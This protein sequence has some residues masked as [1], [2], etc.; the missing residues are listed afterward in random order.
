MTAALAALGG[1]P[2]LCHEELG[3]KG[4][5]K[6]YPKRQQSIQAAH[7]NLLSAPKLIHNSPELAMCVSDATATGLPASMFAESRKILGP[8]PMCGGWRAAVGSLATQGWFASP[9]LRRVRRIM[10]K[11]ALVALEGLKGKTPNAMGTLETSLKWF[12]AELKRQGVKFD[13]FK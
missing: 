6:G 2:F 13:G 11:D 12:L 5:R 10:A 3:W 7:D 9:A 4:K 1:I 8:R